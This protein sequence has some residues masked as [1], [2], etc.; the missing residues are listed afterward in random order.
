MLKSL[1]AK[2]FFLFGAAFYTGI[3]LYLSE[4]AEGCF[5]LYKFKRDMT[6]DGLYTVSDLWAQ[7]KWVFYFPGE[8]VFGGFLKLMPG[9][10]RFF[11]LS[12]AQCRDGLS[13]IVSCTSWVVICIL[14]KV[15][16][17]DEGRSSS[18]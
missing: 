4:L 18:R 15:Y 3:A 14:W 12:L 7:I 8:L 10:A 6:G 17:I 11:E 1:G 9:A 2:V 5:E 16:A 13:F